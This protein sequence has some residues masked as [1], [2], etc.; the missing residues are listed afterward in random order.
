MKNVFLR[1]NI[2]A[3]AAGIAALLAPF[4]AEAACAGRSLLPDLRAEHGAA[5][6]EA[7]ARAAAVPNAEGLL[8]RIETPG[9]APSFLF[10]TVHLTE[11]DG[12]A[13]PA[14]ALARLDGA[15][16]L[17][18]EIDEAEQAEMGRAIQA[19]PALIADLTG[20]TLDDDLSPELRA[21]LD[22]A[23]RP[24]GTRYADIRR[25]RPWFVQVMLAVPP[26]A[27][28]SLQAGAKPM[29]G[30]LA[31]RAAARGVPVAGMERWE[32]ALAALTDLSRAEAVDGLIAAIGF[33]AEA[34]DV[35]ATLADVWAREKPMMFW[36]LSRL[37][38]A[39]SVGEA[40]SD[41]LHARLWEGMADRRNRAFAAA[42]APALDAGGAFVAVGALHLPGAE[43][44]VE[45]FR[46]QGR[47]VTR[48]ALK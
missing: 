22:A 46:A 6:A 29:D 12:A 18:I 25:L 38:T 10:G 27:M 41:A 24:Y 15:R 40:R 13:P 3:A 21:R 1:R 2:R 17:L 19:D 45:L 28:A 42:A 33:A 36:E 14:A 48:V 31:E 37:L 39:E 9:A 4:G 43:G 26:C 5:F 30:A 20:R 32:D 23:L 47:T 8:W 16:R 11:E 7:E 44:L 35:Q 34:E